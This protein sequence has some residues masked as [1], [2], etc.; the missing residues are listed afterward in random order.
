MRL[1]LPAS[2]EYCA[3]VAR[4]EAKNFYPS[5]RLLPAGQR[6]SMCALYAFMR[7]TDDLADDDQRA[8][9]A[10]RIALDAWRRRLLQEVSGEGPIVSDLAD[11]RGWPALADTARRFGIARG[12]LLDVIDGVAMDL[13]PH[14]LDTNEDLCKYCYHVAGAVGL[15]CIAIWGFESDG[16]RAE[17]LAV[18]TGRALQVTNIVRDVA[19]DA[20]DGRVYLPGEDMARFGVTEA[21]LTANRAIEPLRRLLAFEAARAYDDYRS[22]EALARLVDP[23]GRPV[24]RALVGIYRALLDEIARRDFE[25]LAGRVSVP[26]WRKATIVAGALASRLLPGR[27]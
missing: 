27:F 3:G 18:A 15:C 9:E 10:R 11:W 23:V 13:E 4:R 16:G 8:P 7:R 5:F 25:V 6:Q 1:D 14:S 2:Y 12:L 26:S 17:S 19:E 21:D 22:A 24:L 20:R